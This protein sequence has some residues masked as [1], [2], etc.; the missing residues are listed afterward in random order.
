MKSLLGGGRADALDLLKSIGQTSIVIDFDPDGRVLSANDLFFDRFGHGQTVGLTLAELHRETFADAA[1]LSAFLAGL[2][3]GEVQ[4][5]EVGLTRE[6]GEDVRLQANF[7]PVRNARGRFYKFTEI[8]DEGCGNRSRIAEMSGKLAAISRFQAVLEF[9]PD[10]MILDAN[11][12]A[13]NLLGYDRSEVVGRHHRELVEPSLAASEEYQEFWKKLGRGEFVAGEFRRIAKGGKLVHMQASYNPVHD[14]EGRVL[15]IVKF[16]TD[17]TDR[18]GAV[19]EIGQGLGRLAKGDLSR[20]IEHDFGACLEPIRIDFNQSLDT[21]EA[22]LLRV[23]E[24]AATIG[25]AVDEMRTASDELAERTES[26]AASVE[27]TAAAVAE[28]AG[29]VQSSAANAE[30][31][32]LVVTKAKVGAERSGEIVRKAIA[33]MSAIEQSS[34]QITSIIAVIDEIAFQTNLLALNAGV[35]AARAGEA[36]KGFAVVAQEVRELAQR[37]ATAAKEIKTLI[38]ASSEQVQGGVALVGETGEALAEI[39]G[40]VQVIDEKIRAIVGTAR[41]QATGLAEISR[42]V[43]SIDRSTQQNA[44]MVEEATAA[45]H[46]LGTETYR[47]RELLGTF[48]L[49]AAGESAGYASAATPTAAGRPA[50]VLASSQG[51]AKGARTSPA[52]NLIHD[53]ANAFGTSKS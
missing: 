30:E 17:V 38:T 36:G 25:T 35:E 53:V 50:L 21:L 51:S 32:A 7:Y 4:R 16:A 20:R 34:Q 1:K 31:A 40:E 2:R 22:A 47:L 15:K 37:S 6:S 29:N 10:G 27:E 14:A 19:C 39:V 48:R 49:S 26:Q 24:S 13:L 11:D 45:C 28:L 43:G 42:A 23:G 33:S 52:R 44:T 41:Q 46:N 9:S 18:V 8:F 3:S 12:N 5:T